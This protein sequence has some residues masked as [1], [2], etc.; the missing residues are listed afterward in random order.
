MT[1]F[2]QN[3]IRFA[4]AVVI[5][6]VVGYYLISAF[7][8]VAHSLLGPFPNYFVSAIW[9]LVSAAYALKY[10]FKKDGES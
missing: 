7:T 3:P 1:N 8:G 10:M 9:A 5:L 6:M 4:C 2:F